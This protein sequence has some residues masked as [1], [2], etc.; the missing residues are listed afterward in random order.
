MVK[1]KAFRLSTV[2]FLFLW[3][4]FTLYPQPIDLVKSIYRLI[5]PPVNPYAEGLDF[6]FQSDLSESP[7]S[8]EKKV[9]SVIVYQYDWQTYN[10]PWYFPTIEEVLEKKAGDCKSQM[11]ILASVLEYQRKEYTIKASPTHLWVHY[12]EKGENSSE[13]NDVVLISYDGS[14]GIHIPKIDFIRSFNLFKIAFW[15]Y[16]PNNKKTLLFSGLFIFFSLN[17]LPFFAFYK[18]FPLV[19]LGIKKG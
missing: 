10:L 12:E 3:T 5:S 15:D 1:N 16:M 7:S 8:L 11:L 13:N 18:N 2:V 17:L 4:L 19:L 9:K 14:S 6:F